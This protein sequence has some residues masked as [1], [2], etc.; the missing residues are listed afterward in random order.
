MIYYVVGT[1]P[2]V[3]CQHVFI[4]KAEGYKTING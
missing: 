4:S 3:I 2:T 1:V